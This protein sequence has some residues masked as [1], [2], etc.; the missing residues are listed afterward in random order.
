VNCYKGENII[1]LS[2]FA[3]QSGKALSGLLNA[4]RRQTIPAFR[5]KGVWKI[6][7]DFKPEK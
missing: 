6:A 3:K 5:E 4:A 2:D 7:K 1:R